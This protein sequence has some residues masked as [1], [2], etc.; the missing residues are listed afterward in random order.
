MGKPIKNTALAAKRPGGG[1]PMPGIKSPKAPATMP[2]SMPGMKKGGCVK[3][4]KG[5][6]ARKKGC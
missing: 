5:G 4:A 6:M 2:P 1:M 3:M